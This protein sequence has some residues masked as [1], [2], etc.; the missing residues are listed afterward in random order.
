ML[1]AAPA[2]ALAQGETIAEIRVHGN[3]ATPDADVIALSGLK[4]G[5][6]VTEAR[7]R[8]GASVR[9]EAS[10]RFDGV[11]VLKRFRSIDAPADILVMIVGWERP[12]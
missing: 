8:R 6:A 5:E 3:Y 10:D 4:A 9:S 2:A 11:D 7:L 12:A 1:L